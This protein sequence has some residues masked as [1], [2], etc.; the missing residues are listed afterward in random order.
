MQ[1]EQ[2]AWRKAQSYRVSAYSFLL[3]GLTAVLVLCLNLGNIHLPI[4]A[5]K[6]AEIEI[7]GFLVNVPFRSA[8]TL[9]LK[10]RVR[11]RVSDGPPN[12]FAGRVERALGRSDS[13]TL[14]QL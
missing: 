7:V 9:T 10:Q 6:Q 1:K 5:K 3:H 2:G 14:L 8:P 4:S 12:L 11:V 13:L